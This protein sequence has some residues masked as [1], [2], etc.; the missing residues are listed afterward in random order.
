MNCHRH[1]P[2]I[3]RTNNTGTPAHIPD[4]TSFAGLMKKILIIDPPAPSRIPAEVRIYLVTQRCWAPSRAMTQ[5]E[6]AAQLSR[7]Q[8]KRQKCNEKYERREQ[9]RAAEQAGDESSDSEEAAE[10]GQ[11]DAGGILEAGMAKLSVADD[12]KGGKNG[13]QQE[14]K[15]TATDPLPNP[16]ISRHP[17]L[18]EPLKARPAKNT[19]NPPF[20]KPSSST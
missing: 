17:P 13:Q 19:A 14:S 1:P 5:E 7:N 8:K 15:A 20:G 10:K 6:K 2:S 4:V 18:H 11:D 9:R 16:P 3:T 12:S